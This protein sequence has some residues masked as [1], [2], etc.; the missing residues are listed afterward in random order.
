M[1]SPISIFVV[2]PCH[3]TYAI[4]ICWNVHRFVWF[5]FYLIVHIVFIECAH[6]D[7]MVVDNVFIF[8]V[9]LK[10]WIQCILVVWKNG[11]SR[12]KRN[13]FGRI[14]VNGNFIMIWRVRWNYCCCWDRALGENL[15]SFIGQLIQ[16][17]EFVVEKINDHRILFHT[18]VHFTIIPIF[19]FYNWFG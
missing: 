1:S 4:A 9:Q 5:Y 15:M 16:W 7:F 11:K 18:F 10:I 12:I 14:Y 6:W 3:F 17:N 13:K 8:M 2:I 19:Q